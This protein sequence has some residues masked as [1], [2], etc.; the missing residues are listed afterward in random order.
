MNAFCPISDK[1]INENITRVNALFTVLIIIVFSIKPNIFLALFLTVD[2]FIRAIDAGKYSP[3]GISSKN[4][5]KL[6]SIK[7]QLINAGPK[8]F[9]SQNRCIFKFFTTSIICT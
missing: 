6:F 9:C 2:F 8:L 3:L 5:I 4:I 7:T 1:Q